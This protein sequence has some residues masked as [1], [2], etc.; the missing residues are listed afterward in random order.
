MAGMKNI[1]IMDTTGLLLPVSLLIYL[2]QW[3]KLGITSALNH[4]LNRNKCINNDLILMANNHYK[5]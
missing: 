5:T 1:Q 2:L 3:R 4:L